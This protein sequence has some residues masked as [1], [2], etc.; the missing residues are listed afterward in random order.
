MRRRL[1]TGAGS[2]DAHRDGLPEQPNASQDGTGAL[3]G[4]SRVGAEGAR[5]CERARSRAPRELGVAPRAPTARTSRPARGLQHKT[6]VK[7][8][9]A[10]GI[11]GFFATFSAWLDGILSNYIGTNTAR[12]AQIIAPAIGALA[13]IY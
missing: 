7:E 9:T 1:Y 13:T 3:L 5:L 12:V 2:D 10:G 11:M 8:L 4:E 6:T